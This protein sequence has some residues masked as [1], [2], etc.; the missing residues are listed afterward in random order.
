MSFLLYSLMSSL[1]SCL[2]RTSNEHIASYIHGSLIAASHIQYICIITPSSP[3]CL[4][5]QSSSEIM[6]SV[7]T[8]SFPEESYLLDLSSE[9]CCNPAL[10]LLSRGCS[11]SSLPE[12]K[13]TRVLNLQ[14]VG[15]YLTSI[16]PEGDVMM[17]AVRHAEGSERILADDMKADLDSQNCI[18]NHHVNGTDIRR[19]QSTI[20][21]VID[22]NEHASDHKVKERKRR[23]E[24]IKLEEEEHNNCWKPRSELPAIPLSSA[25]A[26]VPSIS[27]SILI[28][29]RP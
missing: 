15:S 27:I 12:Q 4:L 24:E 16:K 10:L 29:H 17:S 11:H 22:R 21:A 25:V 7:L 18:L 26:Q 13:L 14:G 23:R 6:A 2:L 5:P 19:T 8:A 3:F 20:T 9:G 28:I 1:A